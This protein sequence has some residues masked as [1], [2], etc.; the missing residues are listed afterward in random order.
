MS[1]ITVIGAGNGGMAMAYSLGKSGHEVCIYD[2]PKFPAQVN[3]VKEQGGIEAVAE[4]NDAP[5]L[6]AGFAK[7]TLATTDIKEAMEFADKMLTNDPNN[8][9]YLYVK[10]YL[11]HNMKEYDN[12]IEYYKKAI[13]AD[14]EY[15]EAYSNVGLVYLM[16]AQD[17]ADKAT[18][19]INDPKYAEAQAAVK[20][21]YEE[22][23]PF[24]EKARALKPDQ[25]D[26]WLQGLYRVYYNLNMG[27]EFEEI[28]KM[29]K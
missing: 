6:N 10:A 15:A 25:K 20:K 9:L 13:A 16:K 8:K 22:A 27:P 29:M 12:A 26:L 3:A 23:K 21:F 28:D 4:L 11:Y 2:S 5:M 18:T 24:Y 7:I 19:D 14:P 1:K 17:Y